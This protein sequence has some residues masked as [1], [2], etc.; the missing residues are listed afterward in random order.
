MK[1]QTE[2][3]DQ[4]LHNQLNASDKKA[5]ETE[6]SAN[7]NLRKE[8]EL[9]REIMKGIEQLGMRTE[10][11]Q[12]IKKTKFKKLVRN[13]ALAT[14]GLAIVAGVVYYVTTQKSPLK[15][16]EILH[17]L[18]EKGE[19][20]WSEADR[21]LPSQLFSINPKRDTLIETKSGI[22]L[23]LKANGFLNKFG[24]VPD[25][26]IELEV[27]E[28]MTAADIIKAGLST[29]SNGALLETGGMFYINARSGEESLTID[30]SKSM[31]VNVPSATD[32]PMS[33]FEG[34]RTKTGDINWINP[35]PMKKQLATVDILQLNFY[36]PHFLDSLAQMGFDIKNK[37][38]TDSIYF[39]FGNYV[40]CGQSVPP[41][42]PEPFAKSDT[43]KSRFPVTIVSGGV[44]VEKKGDSPVPT[45]TVNR[46]INS[47][48]GRS[49][50]LAASSVVL[51][52]INIKP[53][54]SG[55][56]LFKQN[57]AACHYAHND[58][59]L[60][61]PGLINVAERAPKGDWLV[62]YILNNE[63]LIKSGDP[64]ANKIY[65]KYG[66]A[67][68]TVFEGQLNE[69]DVNAILEYIN[70]VTPAKLPQSGKN[71]IAEINP[72]RIQAIWD[73]KLNGTI[74]ATK[75]FEERLQVIF[76]SCKANLLSLYTE[77]LD[78]ELYELD[79]LAAFV[80]GGNTKEKF[81]EF[82]KRRDGGVETDGKQNADLQKYL[83]EK[84]AL[85]DKAIRDAMN[86]LY[87]NE[88]SLADKA[89]KIKSEYNEKLSKEQAGLLEVEIQINLTELYRQ[90]GK[91][92]E[93][94]PFTGPF[95]LPKG[96]LSVPLRTTGWCN[97]D[98][99]AIIN[100]TGRNT[101]NFTD[102][103]TNRQALIEYAE[104]K[105]KVNNYDDYDKLVCYLLSDRLTSFQFMKDSNKV[106]KEKLNQ[107][108]GNSLIVVGYKGN[109]TFYW[110]EK[111]A[112]AQEYNVNLVEID[113]ETLTRRINMR[114]NFAGTESIIRDIDF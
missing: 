106:F 62:K 21:I 42:K 93:K 44:N 5:F 114:Y 37:T 29:T 18:N 36:P 112:K 65:K 89:E 31:Q 3:I 41:A 88:A 49:L 35:V 103:S 11:K 27:K 20:N 55:E 101:I 74:L 52:Q 92:N 97:V 28:A 33:L 102:S 86:K 107:M 63:K 109:K 7:E 95:N 53:Q 1:K 71:C 81:I 47:V 38:L 24:E 75:A 111:Y 4:Y 39:S 94:T 10:I 80:Y 46:N 72:S 9:Q 99:Y 54:L 61:G 8:V 56:A 45:T 13:I 91:V 82:M 79:S 48:E 83:R 17:E 60:T 19:A 70:S 85:Y 34:Q 50:T 32:K 6:L 78:K 2:I 73:K 104:A 100:T 84:Q 96:Y 105:V 51:N 68:M 98:S 76:S 14:T 113:S 67:A 23:Q 90:L 69:R 40:T 22:I 12:S 77:N 57:C 66:K 30:Q 15:K 43:I 26:E 64:Y 108:F 59:M 110:D 16:S 25:K 87:K 58:K